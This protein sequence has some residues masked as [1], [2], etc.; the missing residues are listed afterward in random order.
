MWTRCCHSV[1]A[2]GLSCGSSNVTDVF[3]HK[4]V[5]GQ[6]HKVHK[7]REE[8]DDS[9]KGNGGKKKKQPYEDFR[10]S[11]TLPAFINPAPPPKRKNAESLNT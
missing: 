9:M 1:D 8:G 11:S 6:R 4:H 3:L 10:V 7:H 5:K 2:V